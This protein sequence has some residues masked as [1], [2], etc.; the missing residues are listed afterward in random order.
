MSKCID[1][2]YNDGSVAGGLLATI[3]F[4]ITRWTY[5]AFPDIASLHNTGKTLQKHYTTVT[6]RYETLQ[7]LL[8]C[9]VRM[10]ACVRLS[11]GRSCVCAASLVTH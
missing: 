6:E 10:R 4:V 5:H 7:N 9:C 3:L 2:D 11:C 1:F 8:N